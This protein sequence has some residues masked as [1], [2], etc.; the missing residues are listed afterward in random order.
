M[1]VL[2]MSLCL[3]VCHAVQSSERTRSH[4]GGNTEGGPTLCL[5]LAVGFPYVPRFQCDSDRSVWGE[6]SQ[7]RS[8]DFRDFSA[9]LFCPLFDVVGVC[10]CEIL[11]FFCMAVNLEKSSF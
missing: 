10:L 1:N 11:P 8:F 4:Y 9:I 6:E 2:F 3:L 7:K 5:R